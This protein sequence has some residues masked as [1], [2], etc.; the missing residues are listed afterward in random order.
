MSAQYIFSIAGVFAVAQVWTGRRKEP[1]PAFPQPLFVTRNG[2]FLESAAASSNLSFATPLFSKYLNGFAKGFANH[3]LSF[4][5]FFPKDDKPFFNVFSKSF[6]SVCV[7]HTAEHQDTMLCRV[8]CVACGLPTLD[9]D[10][11]NIIVGMEAAYTQ[12]PSSG[13]SSR[14][15]NPM[16]QVKIHAMELFDPC[17]CRN[18]V[19]PLRTK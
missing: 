6:Q 1:H 14:P 4:T 9:E 13:P 15:L 19:G 7:L 11:K 8:H 10:I 16:C 12:D 2:L 17:E 3:W 18:H 5:E